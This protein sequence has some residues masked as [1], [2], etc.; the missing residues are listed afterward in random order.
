MINEAERMRNKSR[1]CSGPQKR[2][3]EQKT[4]STIGECIFLSLCEVN[5]CHP[6]IFSMRGYMKLKCV[7]RAYWRVMRWSYLVHAGRHFPHIRERQQNLLCSSFHRVLF[8]CAMPARLWLLFRTRRRVL[9]Q[10]VLYIADHNMSTHVQMHFLALGHW[11]LFAP[12]ICSDWLNGSLLH[13]QIQIRK[14][15]FLS[16]RMS[17]NVQ[18]WRWNKIK[19]KCVWDLLTAIRRSGGNQRSLTQFS[20]VWTFKFNIERHGIE[21]EIF[22]KK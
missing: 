13:R 19:K 10:I 3:G 12:E 7:S 4:H 1:S 2:V 14:Q 17:S 11:L 21:W 8:C 18:S 15:S 16:Y 5:K 22:E 6:Y 20:M 9:M